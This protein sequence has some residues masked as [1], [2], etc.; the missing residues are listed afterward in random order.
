ML[1][2]QTAPCHLS[3]EHFSDSTRRFSIA[4]YTPDDGL[5][6]R[7]G[8]RG[9]DAHSREIA[10]RVLH[11]R[12]DNDIDLEDQN[13]EK[14]DFEF[15][16]EDDL[17]DEMEQAE[18]HPLLADAE[19]AGVIIGACFM[20][21]LLICFFVVR[22]RRQHSRKLHQPVQCELPKQ[23]TV[24]NHSPESSLVSLLRPLQPV[25]TTRPH[26]DSKNNL[27]F[28]KHL[29]VARVASMDHL[30]PSPKSATEFLGI[31]EEC[32]HT[33]KSIKRYEFS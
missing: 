24:E 29:P 7:L 25:H 11:P 27:F 13:R 3:P 14:Q 6:R 32:T 4:P 5:R 33:G 18:D 30:S 1:C 21:L 26:I 19:L 17:L 15:N 20:F 28:E 8:P 22:H 12:G 9:L 2:F 31:V 16:E 10:S 23:S